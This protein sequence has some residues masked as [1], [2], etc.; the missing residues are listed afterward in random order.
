MAMAARSAAAAVV[1]A[2]QKK[3]SSRV[4]HHDDQEVHWSAMHIPHEEEIEYHG[5]IF[6]EK[7]DMN[8]DAYLTKNHFVIFARKPPRSYLTTFPSLRSQKS[9]E[10]AMLRSWKIS[11][12]SCC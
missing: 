10:S 9:L 12:P 11:A 1:A 4:H 2:R 7:S 3:N 8:I 6:K 5:Q